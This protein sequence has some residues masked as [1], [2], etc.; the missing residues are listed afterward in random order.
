[1]H[2]DSVNFEKESQLQSSACARSH[3]NCVRQRALFMSLH[4]VKL[5]GD[6]GITIMIKTLSIRCFSISTAS[7]PNITLLADRERLSAL[8]AHG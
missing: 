4:C 6:A 8:R 2:H 1:M 5:S 3:T 7:Q